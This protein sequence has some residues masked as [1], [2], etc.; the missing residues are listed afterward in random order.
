MIA[1]KKVFLHFNVITVVYQM[2]LTPLTHFS[3]IR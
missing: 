3:W 1:L 2:S